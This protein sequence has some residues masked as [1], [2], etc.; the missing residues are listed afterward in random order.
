LEPDN[1]PVKLPDDPLFQTD[2]YTGFSGGDLFSFMPGG[3]F[4][5]FDY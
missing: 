1:R 4:S 5:V 2:A 3:G